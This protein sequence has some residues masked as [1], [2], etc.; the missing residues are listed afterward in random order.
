MRYDTASGKT[1]Q[2]TT[3]RDWDIR[4]PSSDEKSRIIYERDGELEVLDVSSKKTSRLSINVPDDGI[5]K[6]RQTGFGRESY[7]SRTP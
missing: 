2:V 6:R 3:N 4:W 7:Y 1:S 5:N